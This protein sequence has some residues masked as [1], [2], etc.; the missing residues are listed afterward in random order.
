MIQFT[1]KNKTWSP[2]EI[3]NSGFRELWYERRTKAIPFKETQNFIDS[4]SH[5]EQIAIGNLLHNIPTSV[6]ANTDLG[7]YCLKL[8]MQTV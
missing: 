6:S 4:W 7:W 8:W 1:F 3:W 5:E 2:V